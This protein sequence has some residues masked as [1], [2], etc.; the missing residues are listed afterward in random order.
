MLQ[1]RLISKFHHFFPLLNL[2]ITIPLTNSTLMHDVN[3]FE[4]SNSIQMLL[5]SWNLTSKF[6]ID[7]SVKSKTKTKKIR[8]DSVLNT[9]KRTLGQRRNI[10]VNS[11]TKYHV[12]I[13]KWGSCSIFYFFCFSLMNSIVVN[14]VKNQQYHIVRTHKMSAYNF[15]GVSLKK[16]YR[17]PNEWH[18]NHFPAIENR[19]SHA[20]LFELP[21]EKDSKTPP[22]PHEGEMKW[23]SSHVKLPC[24]SQNDYKTESGVRISC[25]FIQLLLKCLFVCQFYWYQSLIFLRVIRIQQSLVRDGKLL[26]KRYYEILARAVNWNSQFWRTIPSIQKNGNSN[27]CTGCLNK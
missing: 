21:L 15:K 23:D 8:F 9:T 6:S 10:I 14:L 22:K 4:L 27:R 3:I 7:T 13:N 25:F 12:R 20:V 1:N 24:A 11:K 17:G 2:F 5:L 18:L 16:I 19:R 26:K